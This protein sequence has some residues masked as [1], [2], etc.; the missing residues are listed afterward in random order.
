MT[1]RVRIPTTGYGPV[2]DLPLPPVNCSACFDY[3]VEKARVDTMIRIL[4]ASL[5]ARC[6]HVTDGEAAESAA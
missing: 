2:M 5:P 3:D 4:L 1:L 6:E